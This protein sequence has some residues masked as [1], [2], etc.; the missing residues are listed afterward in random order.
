MYAFG[1]VF[2]VCA[3]ASKPCYLL[4]AVLETTR[5]ERIIWKCIDRYCTVMICL[6]IYVKAVT[7]QIVSQLMFVFLQFQHNAV[8]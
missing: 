4:A 1:S 7:R 8:S 2:L 3:F 6:Y 5:T